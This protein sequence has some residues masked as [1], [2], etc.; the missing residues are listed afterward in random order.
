MKARLLVF[1]LVASVLTWAQGRSGG[2][3]RPSG[4]GGGP[5]SG[6]GAPSD[7]GRPDTAGAP[8]DVGGRPSDAGKPTD[9]GSQAHTQQP[10][11]DSQINSGAFRML[12]KKTGMTR[13]ELQA[14][15]TSSGAK[16]FGQFISAI[17]VAKNLGLDMN[18][19]LDGLKTQSLGQTLQSLGVSPED[20]KKEEAKAKKEAKA[21]NKSS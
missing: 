15:Y 20:A 13:E 18:A 3:G 16:N 4:T 5:P 6:V 8:S 10:L 21:A 1:L 17:V 2:A 7:A 9:A 19:V 12:E 14:L 11:K